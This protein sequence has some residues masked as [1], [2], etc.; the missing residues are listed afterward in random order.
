[1]ALYEDVVYSESGKN[2][3]NSFMQY[4]IPSRQDVGTIRVE[5]ESSYEQPV[6]L[7]QNPS[8]KL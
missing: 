6:R 7:V 1:M 2:F 4:K 3:S 5:F 8:E